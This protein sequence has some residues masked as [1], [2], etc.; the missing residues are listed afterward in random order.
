MWLRGLIRETVMNHFW[1]TC[2]FF[3]IVK[4]FCNA[5]KQKQ[6]RE[7]YFIQP[8]LQ[9]IKPQN[10]ADWYKLMNPSDTENEW[11]LFELVEVIILVQWKI[12]K[13]FRFLKRLYFLVFIKLNMIAFR[14]ADQTEISVIIISTLSFYV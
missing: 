10:M 3:L 12:N 11:E 4:R 6:V 14:T 13:P 7:T 8:L 9:S 1:I 2:V 5:A